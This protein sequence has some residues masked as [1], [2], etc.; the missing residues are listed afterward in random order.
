[1]KLGTELAFIE[2]SDDISLIPYEATFEDVQLLIQSKELQ[3]NSRIKSFHIASLKYGERA[4]KFAKCL[5]IID[6]H[7]GE[8]HHYA[9]E[10]YNVHRYRK[11]GWILKDVYRIESLEE[12]YALQEFLTVIKEDDLGSQTQTRILVNEDDYLKFE[13][14]N[15]IGKDKIVKSLLEN[16]DGIQLVIEQGGE[17]LLTKIINWFIDKSTY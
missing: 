9:V 10:I 8:L 2:P 5:E 11:K 7:T 3:N 13:K 14:L 6:E 12:L 4:Y 15:E 1:M 17:N 16:S